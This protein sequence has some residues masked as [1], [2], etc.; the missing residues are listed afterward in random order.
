MAAGLSL[1][2][3]YAVAAYAETSRGQAASVRGPAIFG[4]IASAWEDGSDRAVPRVGADT[5][6]LLRGRMPGAIAWGR[7]GAI[8]DFAARDGIQ[9]ASL[10]WVPVPAVPRPLSATEAGKLPVETAVT[11]LRTP[12]PAPLPAVEA[13]SSRSETAM[14]V[15]STLAER[16]GVEGLGAQLLEDSPLFGAKRKHSEPG[17]LP[18]SRSR[19]LDHVY[20]HAGD[21]L[22]VLQFDD[23]V[24]APE[25]IMPFARG[26]VTSLFNQGRRHPAIDLAG[27][28]GSP[29]LATTS[30]QKVIFAGPRGGYG[31]AVIT[32]DVYGRTHLYGHLQRITSRVG[33]M[34]DQGDKLG[35]LGSTGHSTGPHVHYEVRNGKGTHINPVTLLFPGRGVAKG[36]AWLD[37]RQERVVAKVAARSQ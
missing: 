20:S 18:M 28:L 32:Q 34:L 16:M 24:P 31:N 21:P 33:Q 10:T 2:A 23:D 35:H 29:V 17:R 9:L 22:A 12:S 11:A 26:R 15:L 36:Y 4:E 13:R 27:K 14:P 7:S 5:T 8:R 37:V 6:L 3:G 25:F 19:S 1:A 30:R